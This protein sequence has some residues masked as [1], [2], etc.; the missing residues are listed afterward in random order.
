MYST[1]AIMFCTVQDWY[2]GWSG[3]REP[4]IKEGCYSIMS[5]LPSI[6]GGGMEIGKGSW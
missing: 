6:G 3:N 4:A 5:L 2:V 1:V